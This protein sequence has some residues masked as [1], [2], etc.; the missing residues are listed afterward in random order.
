[1]SSGPAP[2]VPD[3]LEALERAVDG[4]LEHIARMR[5]RVSEAEARS[6]ELEEIVQRF[7][8]DDAEVT[9]LLTRLRELEEENDDLRERL[10]VG[11]EG[12]D[13]LLAQIRFLET[14]Q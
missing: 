4:A 9:L 13:R 2:S 11:R 10:R 8:G 6:D 12:I 14:Q 1:M 3:T 7:T 5:S